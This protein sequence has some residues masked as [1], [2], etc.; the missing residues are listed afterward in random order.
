V[1]VYF[2]LAPKAN[3]VKIGKALDPDKRLKELQTGNAEPLDILLTL[4]HVAP[5][6]ENQLHWRFRKYRQHGEWFE[7][8]DE[9][10][11][12]V[13]GKRRDPR[14]TFEDDRALGPALETELDNGNSYSYPKDDNKPIRSPELIEQGVVEER[15]LD[16]RKALR[17][18]AYG[19]RPCWGDAR[20]TN[21]R[22][23]D[24]VGQGYPSLL[25]RNWRHWRGT[26]DDAE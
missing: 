19:A 10:R 6:E 12:F 16:D 2:I 26:D 21:D 23:E 22:E 25:E 17:S 24:F 11:R 4:P 3:C 14:S 8:R 18:P 20:D 7:Y 5:F 13:E 9:V 1:K 15:A